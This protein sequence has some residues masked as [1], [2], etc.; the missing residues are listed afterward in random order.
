MADDDDAHSLQLALDAALKGVADPT[1]PSTSKFNPLKKVIADGLG[2]DVARVYPTWVSKPGNLRV[3]LWQSDAAVGSE[4]VF[5]IFPNAADIDK[6]D[7]PAT[8]ALSRGRTQAVALVA[9]D[10]SAWTVKRVIHLTGSAIALRMHE[11]WPTA[12][13]VPVARPTPAAVRSSAPVVVQSRIRRMVELAIRTYNAVLLV[14]PPGTGKTTLLDDVVR[15]IATDP[16]AFGFT[17]SDIGVRRVS[18]EESW[19]TR[20]LV[21]GETIDSKGILR[22]RPGAVL[23]AIAADDWL[24]LDEANRADMDRIFGGLL[25]WL[26]NHEVDV[27]RASTDVDA[28]IVQLGWSDARESVVEGIEKLESSNGDPT[29]IRF[30]AGSEWRLLGTYNPVDAQRVFRFGAALGRRFGHVPI[31][32]PTTS[33]FSDILQP[34]L[35]GLSESV[36]ARVAAFYAAHFED[37]LTRFGPALFLDIPEYVRNGIARAKL[38]GDDGEGPD[39]EEDELEELVAE[40]YLVGL[41]AWLCRLDPGDLEQ[42]G[43]RVIEQRA[44]GTDQWSWISAQ[45]PTLGG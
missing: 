29:P 12:T 19:T 39:L 35:D 5:A 8:A 9:K 15:D 42:L 3:R 23:Q 13:L 18:P 2:L 24:V 31:P 25:T 44:V 37:D 6:C 10:S 36:G 33:S 45:M 27:G 21:G 28:P 17:R 26:S 43:M 16:A 34:R 1:A 14:G 38:S 32:A 11:V 40:G 22:F 30:C 4:V 7:E 41:G 20:E